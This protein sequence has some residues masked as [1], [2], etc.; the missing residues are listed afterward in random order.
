M[1]NT[2][3]FAGFFLLIL[4]SACNEQEEELF[5]PKLVGTWEIANLD[6]SL[7][8]EGVKTLIFR[9]DGT[10]S[11]E[12]T[13][14]RPGEVYKGYLLITNGNFISSGDQISLMPREIFFARMP[15]TGPP[16]SKEELVK[17][18]FSGTQVDKIQFSI[19]EDSQKLL[20]PYGSD[21]LYTKVD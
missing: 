14:R 12:L 5:S 1:K 9:L 13:Y 20:L 7:E 3:Q 10:Y 19:S 6:S 15:N 21:M 8:L 18:D 17:S 11:N 4:F 16:Y 2:I